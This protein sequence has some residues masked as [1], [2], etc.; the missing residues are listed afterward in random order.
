MVYCANVG[1]ATVDVTDEPIRYV[2]LAALPS[3]DA[4]DVIVDL[5][6]VVRG[7]ELW[8]VQEDEVMLLPLE[9]LDCTEKNHVRLVVL[10]HHVLVDLNNLSC[11]LHTSSYVTISSEKMKMTYHTSDRTE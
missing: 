6:D 8:G 3:P 7:E 9:R 11:G 4:V 10:S 5:L 2:L 1:L